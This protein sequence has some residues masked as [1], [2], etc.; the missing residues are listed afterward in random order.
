MSKVLN[1]ISKK[2][3]GF[4][5]WFKFYIPIFFL[6]YSSIACV[7]G[8]ERKSIIIGYFFA[9]AKSSGSIVD[10]N[11]ITFAVLNSE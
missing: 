3:L 9:L 8:F 6:R 10:D 5:Y 2:V 11:T 4:K 7:I 1:E